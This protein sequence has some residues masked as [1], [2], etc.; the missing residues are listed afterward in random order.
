MNATFQ[1]FFCFALICCM[2]LIFSFPS[3]SPGEQIANIREGDHAPDFTLEDLSGHT[4][5]LSDYKGKP[6]ILLFMTTW[7]R[8]TWK[9]IP[10]MKE[11]YSLYKSKGLVIFNID[12]MEPGEKAERFAKGHDILYPTLLDKDG[13]VSR[14]FG[15]VGVPMVVLINRD[16]RISCWDCP[17]LANLLEELFALKK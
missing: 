13:E 8:G 17:N 14:K 15:I 10:H 5:K 2:F 7:I 16:G 3:P 1:R 4:V 11:N 9:M 6:V 12:V